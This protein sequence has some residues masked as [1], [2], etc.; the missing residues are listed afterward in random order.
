MNDPASR[1]D[2]GREETIFNAAVQ[3]RDASKRA[4]YLDLACEND[5]GLRARIERLLANDADDTF[6][7][8]PL[9][10]PSLLT[11]VA[12]VATGPGLQSPSPQPEAE[13]IGRY[14]LIQKIGEGGC[15]VVYM[16][17]QQE[18][19]RRKVALKV[20]KLGMDTTS[21][22]SR[23]EAERQALALMDHANIAKVLDA[24]ATETGR[25]YFVMELVGGIKIT[26]Y[27]EQNNLTT[28]QRLDLFIQIC[29]AIQH[30]HQKGV[31]HRDIKPSN[32]LVAIQDGVP[33]PKVID[34][35]IAKATQGKLTDQ[36]VFTAFEQ[37][38][39]T[40]AYMSPEQAQLGGL[41]VDTRSDIYS[42]GVLLYELLTGKT[43]FDAKELLAEGLDVMR[44]TIQEKEPLT[45]ST[46]LKQERLMVAASD[47]G[48]SEIRSSRSE[49]DKD[50][51]WI[52]MKC[53]EKDRG[54][55]YE[56][57]NGLA[58]DIE[59]HVRNEP[60]QAGPPS[61][62][63]RFQKLVRRNKGM[64]TATA[65]IAVVLVLGAVV[66][67]WQA[68]RATQA[69]REQIRLRQQAETAQA[70][71]ERER[72][73]AQT[74]AAKSKE[75][76]QFLKETLQGVGPSVAAGRDTTMLREILDKTV[77]R[78][79]NDL[80]NQPEVE[81]ELR[82]ILAKTYEELGLYKEMEVM[83][84]EELRV[85]RSRL[86]EESVAVAQA[87]KLQGQALF[88]LG[89]YERSEE[90][91]QAALR[92]YQRLLGRE[93]TEVATVLDNL[94]VALR[95]RSKLAEAEALQ[96][97]CLTI[98]QRLLGKEHFEVAEALAELSLSLQQEGK[99]AEAEELSHQALEMMRKVRGSENAEVA[100]ILNNLGLI[101][102]DEGK[103][104]EEEAVHRESLAMRRKLLGNE[105]PDVAL[106]LLNLADA[107]RKEGKL[108]EAEASLREALIV[109]RKCYGEEHREVAFSL[110]ALG[111]VLGAEHRLDEAEATLQSALAMRR[112]LLGGEH[113]DV[114]MSLNN[115]GKALQ[116]QGRLREAEAMFRESL[117]M[118]SKVLGK[119]HALVAMSLGNLAH[120]LEDL[121]ELDEAEALYREALLMQ[122]K[123]LGDEHPEVSKSVNNLVTLLIRRGK[124]AEAEGLGQSQLVRMRSLFPPDAPE[125]ASMLSQLANILAKQD[126]FAEAEPLARESLRIRE[127]RAP[128]DWRTF[129][130]QR[131]LAVS[132]VGLKRY[133][134][135]EPLLL[136]SFQ[137][138]KRHEASIPPSNKPLLKQ[139][140]LSLVQLY[141]ANGQTD[142]ATKWKQSLDEYDRAQSEKQ[143]AA[144][145]EKS[146]H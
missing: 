109:Q 141:E 3:L 128:D 68:V 19:V 118:L 100:T 86:G 131:Q 126:K 45:P 20:I 81:L 90:S 18:P 29:Q 23:F 84:R 66:S 139:A 146:P 34:F 130:A 69:Q 77:E 42:L 137:G 61:G 120:V 115:L 72:Q 32:A 75:V 124:L 26:D 133:P 12:P 39:G 85:A 83:S 108:P 79:G 64:V 62:L 97:E 106:S 95:S 16:A 134:E 105:H 135:A 92:I 17:E 138:I 98:R 52:V 15:G 111:T 58:M 9:A 76:A 35:G 8:Q 78:I 55:R 11:S 71:K 41:D 112:K 2:L 22:I 127:K 38:L 96:R 53:L 59:R 51:D 116:E 88:H 102:S 60:V 63:Y 43:P 47:A 13:R 30:A 125:L 46:R 114:A 67:T 113:E 140:L 48:K 145:P 33:V 82:D 119:E 107:L 121:S 99:L 101:L 10:R 132:L 21:V 80:T 37:F 1:E 7:A 44:K 129:N 110:N 5:P 50:L 14:K 91:S 57:A 36:T 104:A 122:R 49:I 74:E 144:A 73:K 70:E 31:I 56:T 25:P 28:R 142:Q 143:A 117:A 24:G 93:S 6:F 123:L 87:L 54:R 103:V 136:S 40:P 94:A 27:C 4:I 89:H 65:A